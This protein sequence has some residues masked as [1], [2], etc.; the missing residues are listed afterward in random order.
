MGPGRETSQ[1]PHSGD[2]PSPEGVSNLEKEAQEGLIHALVSTVHHFF[3]G[4]PPLS[5][6]T[7]RTSEIL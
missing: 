7:F 6:L 4:F 1:E 5:L 2:V 3:G